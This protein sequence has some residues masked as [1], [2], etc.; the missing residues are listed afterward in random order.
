MACMQ[1]NGRILFI[2]TQ[3]DWGGVQQYIVKAAMEARRRGFDVL[4]AYGGKGDLPDECAGAGI[5]SRALEHLVRPLAPMKDIKGIREIRALLREWKP[6]TV[7]LHSSKA[8]VLGSIAAHRED[9]P[10]IVYRIGGWSFLDPVS[11]LQKT[12]RLWMEKLT[13]PLKDVIIVVHPGDAELAK[14]HGIIAREA[15]AAIPNGLDIE[16]FESRLLPREAA[17]S[18]LHDLWETDVATASRNRD[19]AHIILTIANF[20]PTKDLLGYMDAIKLIRNKNDL[21][22]LIVGDGDER[23]ML[24]AKRGELGLEDRVSLPGK[25][26]NIASLL[27]GADMFVLPSAKEG[28]PWTLLEA[29]AASIP[30]IAT[31]VGANRWMLGGAGIIVPPKTPLAL[32][33]A[34]DNIMQRPEKRG[35]MGQ[36]G[37]S[38]I[39]ERFQEQRMW[40]DTFRVLA[41]KH[42]VA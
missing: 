31:D 7:Y 22:F 8:G 42:G 40:D 30:C 33:D 32:A 1:E 19:A 34:I 10:R 17:R 37:R 15:I 41:P 36:A 25:R 6:D 18:A 39:Q 27:R 14:R 26:N 29:M 13:A 23:R 28:M 9:V 38:Q 12:L 24:E 21:R 35:M 20:Y 3:A 2:V 16:T 4:V 11:P 5:A